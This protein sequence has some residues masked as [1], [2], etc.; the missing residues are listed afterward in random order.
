MS[1]AIERALDLYFLDESGCAPTL[2]VSYTW[3][4]IG[5]RAVVPYVAPKGAAST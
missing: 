3:A 1:Q 4:R 2:P 5:T